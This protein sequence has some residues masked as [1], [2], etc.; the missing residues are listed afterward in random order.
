M[1]DDFFDA[2][3]VIKILIKYGFIHEKGNWKQTLSHGFSYYVNF[4]KKVSPTSTIHFQIHIENDIYHKILRKDIESKL[5]MFILNK[6]PKNFLKGY[7]QEFNN[8]L[9][10]CAIKVR[11][12]LMEKLK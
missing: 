2:E 4:E 1:K 11:P 5:N 7:F 8:L 9:A 3:C 10:T 6:L 12:A